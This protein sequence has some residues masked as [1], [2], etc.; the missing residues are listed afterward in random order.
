MNGALLRYRVMA[1][2]VGVMLIVVFV[3]IPFQ[4]VERPVGFTH[5][6]LYLVYLLTVLDLVRRARLGFWTL[7]AMV[8][9]GW[10]P[11]LAFVVERWVT[12]RV[13]SAAPSSR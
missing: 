13:E 11:F 9:G 12:R 3:S 2:V 10:V 4:S 8:C 6:M 1:Y 7:V 5:G